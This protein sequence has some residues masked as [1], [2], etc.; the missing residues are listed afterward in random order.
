MLFAEDAGR[1]IKPHLS[2]LESLGIQMGAESI[3]VLVQ[4]DLLRQAAPCHT[5]RVQSVNAIRDILVQEILVQLGSNVH[6]ICGSLEGSGHVDN[7]WH[8]KHEDRIGNHE[9]MMH[10]RGHTVVVEDEVGQALR[11]HKGRPKRRGSIEASPVSKDDG[12]LEATSLDD[13]IELMGLGMV[14]LSDIGA[15]AQGEHG[16]VHIGTVDIAAKLADIRIIELLSERIRDLAL[17]VGVLGLKV[18][19]GDNGCVETNVL[20]L[21]NRGSHEDQHAACREKKASRGGRLHVCFVAY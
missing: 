10:R 9:E 3:S 17:I 19:G 21:S 1:Q 18:S 7:G 16:V 15:G 8:T 11:E 20:S 6:T 2:I 4:D 5:N 14:V 13:M 12:V